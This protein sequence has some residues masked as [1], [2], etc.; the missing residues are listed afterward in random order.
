[1]K[2]ILFFTSSFP[3]G[4]GEGFLI[5][6]ISF[7]SERYEVIIAPTFPR[8]LRNKLFFKNVKNLNLPLIKIKYL[9]YVLFYFF[10]N[11]LKF[12][13]IIRKSVVKS[14]G[15]TFRNLALV[16]K[17]IYMSE[18]ILKENNISFFYVHWLS[19][20]SQL[21]LL[22]NLIT[23]I[24]FGITGHRWDVIDNNNFDNK[25]NSAVF[26]RLISDKS[27]DLLSPEIKDKYKNKINVIKMGV[28]IPA[29]K[30]KNYSKLLEIKKGVCVA[31]L[32]PVKGIR[33]LIEAIYILK[34][35]GIVIKLDLIGD[36]ELKEEIRNDINTKGLS[37]QIQML[38]VLSHSEVLKKFDTG[39]YFFCCLPSVDLGN[40]LHEG[41]PVSLMEA[42][43]YGIPCVSTKTGSISE[44]I[45]NDFNGY[46]VRDKDAN[47]I[48][49][50]IFSLINNEDDWKRFSENSYKTILGYF[51]K[52]LN[53]LKISNLIENASIRL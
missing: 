33:Y 14:I 4:K 36:G 34:K 51:N 39:L 42:M 6:E 47:K 52:D 30:N 27:V 26:V 35:E 21:A 38:G 22:I 32:I 46:L 12:I 11:P 25:F 7:L 40:G 28:S 15:K 8:G 50:A 17:A 16:P 48:K 10:K 5:P 19:S 9:F 18:K 1:M 3:Y 53:N 20:P 24:P 41:I 44:L 43:S 29:Y 45:E 31:N 23:K 37:Q 13:E 49:E 2:K